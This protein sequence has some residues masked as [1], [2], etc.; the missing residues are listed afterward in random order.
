MVRHPELDTV[1]VTV[2]LVATKG[3]DKRQSTQFPKWPKQAK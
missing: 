2:D 1:C 3:D